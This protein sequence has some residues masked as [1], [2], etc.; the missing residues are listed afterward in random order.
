M[1]LNDILRKSHLVKLREYGSEI[2]DD[3]TLDDWNKEAFRIA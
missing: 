3:P 1:K 2:P